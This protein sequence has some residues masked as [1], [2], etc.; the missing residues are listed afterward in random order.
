MVGSSP[1]SPKLTDVFYHRTGWDKVWIGAV[2]MATGLYAFALP[3]VFL[4]TGES[5]GPERPLLLVTSLV[6]A[7]DLVESI[8]RSRKENRWNLYRGRRLLLDV[9]AAM[10]FVVLASGLVYARPGLLYGGAT[11]LG[12]VKFGKVR[13]YVVALRLRALQYASTLT[14]ASILLS[15]SLI[16]HWVASGWLLLRGLDPE[17]TL[18]SNYLNALYWTGT[19]ITTVGYGD[20]TPTTDAEKVYSLMTMLVG[21][22]FFGYVVGLVASIWSRRDPGRMEFNQNVEH[23]S[24]AVRT[25]SLPPE[26]QRRIYDYYVYMWR[27][28]GWYDES[29]FLQAL[30]PT[31]RSEVSVHMKQDVLQQVDLFQGA[32]RHFRH[33]VATYLRPEVLT[34]GGYAFR[35]GDEGDRVYFI[36]RGEVEV[37]KGPEAERIRLLGVG[38][39]FGEIALFTE[40]RRT[41]SVR[42]VEFT[43]VYWLSK[44]AFRKVTARFPAQIKPIEDMARARQA[45]T[46]QGATPD[47]DD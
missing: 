38:D 43:E 19:T 4:R 27:E 47:R 23:L 40:G 10:P 6:I 44:D 17:H 30:P 13:N 31:L 42:A 16:V 8:V 21:L 37:L 46:D 33:E 7:L 35:E 11:L 1:F 12:L 15:A 25:T 29:Q 34:P 28:R 26:L 5:G 45:A 20:I 3:W 22:A 9:L 24:H 14:V 18:V 2:S 36:V 41:A 39:F 32:P